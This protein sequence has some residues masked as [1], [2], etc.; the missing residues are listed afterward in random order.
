MNTDLEN[1]KWVL[2]NYARNE[3]NHDAYCYKDQHNVRNPRPESIAEFLGIY[4]HASVANLPYLL[5]SQLDQLIKP[6]YKELYEMAKIEMDMAEY[7]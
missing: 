2:W 1:L 5:L 7:G 6:Q 3:N 4:F